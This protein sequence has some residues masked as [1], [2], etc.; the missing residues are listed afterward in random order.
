VVIA[1]GAFGVLLACAVLTAPLNAQGVEGRIGDLVVSEAA[2]RATPPGATVGAVYFSITNAGATA[3]RLESVSTPAARAVQLHATSAVNG[4]MQMREVGPVECAPGT[5]VKAQPGALHVM[6]IGLS[7][8]LRLGST[9]DVS[10][11]FHAAGVLTLKVP[12]T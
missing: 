12:I 3:D 2:A 5:T 6:L 10:L 1:A 4:V 11:K 8:P 7:A 9:I